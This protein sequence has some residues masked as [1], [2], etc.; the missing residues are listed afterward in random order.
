MPWQ[1]SRLVARPLLLLV[2]LTGVA[3]AAER[4][5]GGTAKRP[6]KPLP[7]EELE[8][9]T[10]DQLLLVASYYAGTREKESLPVLLLHDF[11]GN[12]NQLDAIALEIQR[13]LGAAVIVPDLRGHGSSTTIVR[14]GQK[15]SIEA[16]RITNSDL[17]DIITIDLERVKRFLVEQN[18]EGLLNINKL[19]VVGCGMGAVLAV[20]WSAQDWNWRPLPNG[21]KRGQ[22]VRA[23]VL[24]S[25]PWSFRGVTAKDALAHPDLRR[26]VATMVLVGSETKQ[27]TLDAQ[28]YLRLINP[29][30]T[31]RVPAEQSDGRFRLISPATSLQ[32]ES[33]LTNENLKA[34]ATLVEFLEQQVADQ[35]LPWAERRR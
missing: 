17:A 26:E 1:L 23:L 24:V 21:H 6:S 25:P 8:L 35:E 22:D 29:A 4:R 19:C 20:N 15:V 16:S 14:Q 11:G 31:R 30:R 34:S 33:L 7:R 2:L 3:C 12:R 18:D 13:E 5:D 27:A 10:K 32:S 9:E 28:R